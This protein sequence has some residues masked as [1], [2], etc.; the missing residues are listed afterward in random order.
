MSKVKRVNR[1]SDPN[2]IKGKYTRDQGATFTLRKFWIGK[3]ENFSEPKSQ[4]FVTANLSASSRYVHD[5][6]T[7][8]VMG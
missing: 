5:N 4:N 2:R 3:E 6:T 8:K 7:H 1:W